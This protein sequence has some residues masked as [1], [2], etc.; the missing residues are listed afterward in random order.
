MFVQTNEEGR[1][2]ATSED[3]ASLPNSFEFAF[4]DGFDF[5]MQRDYTIKDGVLSHSESE[6]TVREKSDE[7][8]AKL[9]DTDYVAAKA[10]DALLSCKSITD[11]LSVLASIHSEYA[12]VLKQ[13]EEWRKQI[14][15]L[16]GGGE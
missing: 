5:G 14:N 4:P 6:T 15:E 8:R 11:L 16:A 1:I 3:G 9:R 13:R 2:L 10:T 12:D 7:L